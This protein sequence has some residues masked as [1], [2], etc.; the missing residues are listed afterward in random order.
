MFVR[1]QHPVGIAVQ[2][3]AEIRALFLHRPDQVVQ[4]SRAAVSI[5]IK[6]VRVD[7]NR[8]HFRAEIREQFR[9]NLVGRAVGAVNHD[10][11]GF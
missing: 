5:D 3:R 11:Q 6:T 2:R 8:D 1:Q 7:R 4:M 9:R 10:A